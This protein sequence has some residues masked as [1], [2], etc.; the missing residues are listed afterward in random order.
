MEKP[1]LKQK[2]KKKVIVRRKKKANQSR[3]DNFYRNLEEWVAYWRSN[4]HRF[5]TDYLGF[6]L[7]DFQKVLIYLMF[8]YS[9]F[10]F[11]ASRGLAK[12]TLALIFAVT[13]AI[14]YPN[15]TIVVVAPT[16]SQ[17]TKFIAKIYDLKRT[18][19]NLDNEIETIKI[20]EVESSIKFRGGSK[21]IT[22]PYS[23]NALGQRCNV[24]IVD[25]YVR[26]EK[27][28]IVR[29]FH[30]FLTSPR[31][32]E[33]RS[34]T[35]KA[36]KAIP[37][38]K[39][40]QIYLSSIRGAEEWSYKEFEQYVD[41]ME[42]GDMNYM[43]IALPYNLGVKNGYISKEIV[44]QS[45]KE[46][47]ES[48]EMLLAEYC[49]VPEKGLS[50]SF[51]KYNS[52]DRCRTVYK[53]LTAMSDEEYITYKKNKKDWKYYVE[54]LPNEIRILCMDVALVESKNNDNTAFWVIRLIPNNG[55][56]KKVVS[57]I[58]TSHGVN[59]LMQTKRAKQ[60]FYEMECDW[61]VLDAQGIGM[62]VYDTCVTETY[63]EERGEVYPA[64]VVNNQEDI[65]ML[66]RTISSNAVPIIYSIKTS[67]KEKS[68][69][70]NKMKDMF[71]NGD[72]Q[73]PV[74][75]DDGLD[76]LNKH[77]NYYKLD[78]TD[79]LKQ[80]LLMPYVQTSVFVNEAINLERVIVQGYISA[81]EKSGRR[82]D[83]VMSLV[84]GLS[85]ANELESELGE[86]DDF[87]LSDYIISC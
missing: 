32:P 34:L 5:A 12:S 35:A 73:L 53:C 86:E 2:N 31:Q 41:Y 67:I 27:E 76:Y 37:P 36:R 28:I 9:R 77:Y 42:K 3:K 63:D 64:W 13:Y 18:K 24:L 80:R 78:N 68:Y 38:E 43:T 21:I 71:T 70:L 1:P 26:T 56:Y 16:K 45:F 74:D 84:Y 49:C 7:Y 25:E 19:P 57:Y 6:T 40:K 58:E 11:V 4:P 69:M 48:V 82:K 30:P 23:E 75:Y 66:N 54:K 81:K 65:G 61:F 50:N 10:I 29:V 85:L 72:I 52:I 55:K 44:E 33:Y 51:Y 83:R 59:S 22:V 20:N 39:N 62:G 87:D 79:N 46:N 47:Q 60:L 17:S 8:F 15:T 14:L